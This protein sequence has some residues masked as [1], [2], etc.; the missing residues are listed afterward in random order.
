LWAVEKV[1]QSATL[2]VWLVG[3]KDS[4]LAELRVVSWVAATVVLR[5]VP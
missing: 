5:A 2:A 3:S 4:Q 1:D